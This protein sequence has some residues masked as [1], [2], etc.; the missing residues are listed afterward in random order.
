VTDE[1]LK[2]EKN[3]H[4]IP[5]SDIVD[6]FDTDRIIENTNSNRGDSNKNE[7]STKGTEAQTALQQAIDAL[8]KKQKQS[9]NSYNELLRVAPM[10]LV[11]GLLLFGVAF[12]SSYRPVGNI[13]SYG[14]SNFIKTTD[15]LIEYTSLAATLGITS[16]VNV[17]QTSRND[18]P[19][20][21]QNEKLAT[22]RAVRPVASQRIKILPPTFSLDVIARVMQ[23]QMASVGEAMRSVLNVE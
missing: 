3:T 22:L 20:F 14:A 18:T 5:K 12:A 6:P 21:S 11:T 8:A 7:K 1:Q 15:E 4:G 23:K 2:K 10:L 19:L 17:V 13:V 16:F 9:H